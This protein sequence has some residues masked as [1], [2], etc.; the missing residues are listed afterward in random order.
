V[1]GWPATETETELGVVVLAPPW[2]AACAALV[3]GSSPLSRNPEPASV[4][5]VPAAR[6][7]SGFT[8]NG[9][10]ATADG[11]RNSWVEVPVKVTVVDAEPGQCGVAGRNGFI[12][13]A[14]TRVTA[15]CAVLDDASWTSTDEV[16]ASGKGDH[17]S[18]IVAVSATATPPSEPLATRATEVRT[19]APL[20][21]ALARSSR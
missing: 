8:P 7:E 3:D 14:W 17:R 2:R 21:I 1:A 13:G 5:G 4:T 12:R 16:A 9:W 18:G 19:T 10:A 6:T 11:E 15:P 20:R